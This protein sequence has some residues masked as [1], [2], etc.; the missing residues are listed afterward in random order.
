MYAKLLE[1]GDGGPIAHKEFVEQY[2]FCLVGMSPKH[3]QMPRD[4]TIKKVAKYFGPVHNKNGYSYF[5]VR[6]LCS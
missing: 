6:T 4:L 5:F 3:V 2:K 1:M